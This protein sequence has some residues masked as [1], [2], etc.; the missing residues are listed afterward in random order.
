MSGTQIFSLSHALDMMITS[1]LI[2]L[3]SLTFPILLYILNPVIYFV[4]I[5]Q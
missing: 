5:I 3:P 1:F 4:F 2:A